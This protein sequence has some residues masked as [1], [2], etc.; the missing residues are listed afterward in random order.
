MYKY[1]Y[2]E[3]KEFSAEQKKKKKKL[4]LKGNRTIQPI[5]N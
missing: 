5:I 1:M 4:Q 3:V 2:I